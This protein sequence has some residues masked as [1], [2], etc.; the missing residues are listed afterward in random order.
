MLVG[1]MNCLVNFD[2]ERDLNLLNRLEEENELWVKP[3]EEI[4]EA[5]IW[6]SSN[7][8]Q[9]TFHCFFHY[10]FFTKVSLT[11]VKNLLG[12]SIIL[13]K[14]TLIGVSERNSNQLVVNQRKFEAI[15]GL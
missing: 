6:R 2:N 11:G 13:L 5:V 15:T 12:L 1:G 7:H 8:L 14:G 9:V 10:L 4:V 3:R